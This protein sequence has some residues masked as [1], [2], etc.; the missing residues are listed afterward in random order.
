MTNGVVP[1]KGFTMFKQIFS[2]AVLL[3]SL[4]CF[5]AVDV[6]KANAA[7]LDDIKG[8]GPSLSGKILKER[9][10]GNFKDWPDLMHRVSG[11][12]EKS[13]AKFSTQGLTVNGNDFK[14]AV[15]SSSAKPHMSAK[16]AMSSEDKSSDKSKSAKP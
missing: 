8:I 12:G 5:A 3:L 4:S 13:A 11:I 16:P 6:N 7:E 15:S 14:G 1:T 10:K 9:N 2:A